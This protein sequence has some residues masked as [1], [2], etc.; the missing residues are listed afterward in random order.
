MWFHT[1]WRTDALLATKCIINGG[2]QCKIRSLVF[3]I[4][5]G[6]PARR[7]AGSGT[8][9]RFEYPPLLL[10]LHHNQKL[11]IFPEKKEATYRHC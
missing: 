7:G 3:Q 8:V 1:K 9:K 2:A 11:I 10:G 5:F 6:F 4:T